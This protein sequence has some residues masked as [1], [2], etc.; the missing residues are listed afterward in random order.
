MV[1][2]MNRD[3]RIGN[4]RVRPLW[5]AFALGAAMLGLMLG[6]TSAFAGTYPMYQ[7]SLQSSAVSP[8]WTVYGF[9]TEASTV[10]SDSCSAS[11]GSIGDYVFSNG[12]AGAVTENGNDG[13]Q[14]G[15]ELQVP[16][17]APDVTIQSITGE[18]HAS[19]ATG[20]D[21][22]LGFASAGQGLPGGTE[23]PYGGGG[24][25]S[26]LD[27]WTLPQGGRDFET[28]VNCTTDRSSPTC[29]FSDSTSVP[30]LSDVTLTLNDPV[31]PAVASVS[32]Q[33]ASAAEDHGTVTGS[34]TF[35]FTATDADSGVRSATLTLTPQGGGAPYQHTFDFSGECSYDAWNACPLRQSVG[36]FVLNTA[37][38]G[39]DTYTVE[40]AVINAAG[41][42]ATDTL[43]TLVSDNAP[44]N[45][46]VPSILVPETLQPGSS[47]S[48]Q[49]GAWSAP[50]EAGTV[51]YA[52]QWEQCNGR[53]E[54]CQPIDGAQ[55][56]SYTLTAGDVGDT[57]RVLVSASDNDGTSMLA[58]SPTTPVLPVAGPVS[59]LPGPVT[60]GPPESSTGSPSPTAAPTVSVVASPAP[61]ASPGAS[62]PANPVVIGAPNGIGA[63]GSAQLLLDTSA[64][65]S[66]SYADRSFRL[67]GR[68]LNNLGAP[69]E[70]AMLQLSQQIEGV[71]TSQLIASVRTNSSGAFGVRV[72]AGPSRLVE[73]DYRAFSSDAG[74]A[75][76]ATVRESVLAGVRL[77]VTPRRL[78]SE[79]TITLTGTVN[80]PIP[81]QGAI[82]DLLVHY[83]GRWVPFR[84]PRTN[85]QGGFRVTYQFEGATGRFPFRAE[86][87]AGQSGLPYARGYSKIID[88]L[89]S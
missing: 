62:T 48:A 82:V 68:L 39:D 56:A 23:L 47:L 30:A 4:V 25:Y 40:L 32:G 10:L 7:C 73:V 5:L 61:V 36:G 20:D 83:R 29:L 76:Q 89:T 34:Q 84:A 49:P 70:N 37:T 52:Y 58:S 69:I 2:R 14:V 28:Y 35:G 81:A 8:G 80:G 16:A 87:P 64:T 67:S 3:S 13:S 85:A 79:G 51:T 75:A 66:R 12:L 86:I 15:L 78:S 38:L 55:S 41:N 6:A 44:T 19:P 53:G 54:A 1:V 50:S 42:V 26:A 65:V 88:V 24:E 74:Y 21:A 31:A 72:P 11:G 18:V 46:S 22:F 27:S 57:L 9:D 63:S 45:A 71:G 17:S 60:T 43:G 77:D 59:T 33:L